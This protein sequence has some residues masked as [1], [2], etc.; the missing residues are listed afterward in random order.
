MY[1]FSDFELHAQTVRHV[2]EFQ[3]REIRLAGDRT[4]AREL[5]QRHAN[6]VVAIRRR[7]G[8]SHEISSKVRSRWG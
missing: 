7:I 6:G 3:R 1:S 4:Q 8:E 2:F 5:R